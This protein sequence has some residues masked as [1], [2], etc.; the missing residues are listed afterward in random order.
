MKPVIIAHRGN[1][2][3]YPENSLEGLHSAFKLGCAAV[4]FDIQMLADGTLVIL[5]DDNT[6]RT[7]G[8]NK[9]VLM[10]NYGEMQAISVHEPER[11]SEEHL[12]TP[13]S[14]LESF[15]ALLEEYPARHA[16][17]EV[18]EESLKKWGR[19][20]MINKLLPIIKDYTKQ[21]TVVSFDLPVLNLIRNQSDLTIGW[22]LY[23]YDKASLQ[24]A[25]HTKP[26]YLIVDQ[27][28]L[29]F[30]TPPWQGPWKWMVYG[31]D[32][33]EQAIKHYENGV[34]YIETDFLGRLL[35]DERLKA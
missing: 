26:D 15:M 29:E 21:C 12:P 34:G 25:Q 2:Y 16:Y 31:V 6:L 11:F 33:A 17:I 4:E 5:H 32:S 10:S 20:E 7:S 1:N 13:V 23:N 28:E 22:V 8:V 19:Q 14:Q 27:A 9:E 35:A 30:D 3:T 24:K 18:K